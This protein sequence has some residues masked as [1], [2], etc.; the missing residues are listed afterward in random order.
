MPDVNPETAN[1]LLPHLPINPESQTTLL[2]LHGAF[3]S[4]ET[5]KPVHRHLEQYHL[6]IPTLPEHHEAAN[7]SAS[8]N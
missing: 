3:S 7:A 4:K 1:V 6:L 5:W 8:A 2:L